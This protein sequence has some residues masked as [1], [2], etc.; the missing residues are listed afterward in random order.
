M[1]PEK[2]S[3]CNLFGAFQKNDKEWEPERVLRMLPVL[4]FER[5]Q[6]TRYICMVLCS[7]TMPFCGKIDFRQSYYCQNLMNSTQYV[8]RD[9]HINTNSE[10]DFLS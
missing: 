7:I 6:G 9:M 5:I 10:L 3:T 2:T 1:H 8:K 4:L